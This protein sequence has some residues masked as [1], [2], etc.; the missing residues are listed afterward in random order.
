MNIG[1]ICEF[2]PFHKGHK[3]LIDTLKAGGNRVVCVMSGNFVQR[4]EFAVYDK[5]ERARAALEGGAD[6][7]LE[8]PSCVATSS[9]EGFAKGGVELLESLGC[10][11]AI[12]FGAE[13]DNLDELKAIAEKLKDSRVQEQITNEMKSGIS[14]PAARS[15]VLGTDILDYPNNILACEYLKFTSLPCIAVKRIGG[16][17]NSDDTEYSAS[18][19]RSKLLNQ[20]EICSMANCEDAVLYRLRTMSKKEIAELE[21]VSEGLENRIYDAV[22]EATGLYNLYSLVATK[23]YPLSRLKR[24]ILRAFLGIDKDEQAPPYVRLLGF[25]ENG[26]ELLS[27]IKEKSKLPV[28]S[29][30]SDCD[31]EQLEFF[32][33]ECA[34]TDLYNLG[35]RPPR[36]CGTEQTS[37]IIIE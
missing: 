6:L 7:V 28:I 12:A 18:A 25:N 1:V 11:D 23:R 36:P 30:R 15:R 31:E 9:A 22:R 10:I 14:Y 33:K 21:D 26:R 3:Y 29:K 16:G 24:I 27:E 37:K 19:I 17:Y 2:N 32:E 5:F 35:F 13:N 8:L 20:N 34:R 4:G